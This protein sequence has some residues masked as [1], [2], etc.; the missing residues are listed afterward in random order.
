[1]PQ[2]PTPT[3]FSSPPLPDWA[4]QLARRATQGRLTTLDRLWT[5]PELILRRAG[6]TPDPWQAGVL[7]ARKA[8]TLLLCSRQAGKT[9][10]AAAQAEQLKDMFEDCGADVTFVWQP[11]GHNLT[12]QDITAAREWIA[13]SATSR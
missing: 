9:L 7:R 4:L 1:M 6:L 3:P 5:R 2:T 13:K 10:V 11:G 8:Q 12:N